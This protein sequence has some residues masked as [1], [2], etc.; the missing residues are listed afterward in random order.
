MYLRDYICLYLLCF[1][2]SGDGV[3]LG[4]EAFL[5]L[6]IWDGSRVIWVH[7]SG[8]NYKSNKKNTHL[9]DPPHKSVLQRPGLTGYN[10]HKRYTVKHT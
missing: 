10:T 4:G 5:P 6:N 7:F 3:L 8:V 9:N 1:P 2:L